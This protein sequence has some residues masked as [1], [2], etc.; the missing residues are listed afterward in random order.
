[1]HA[2][3]LALALAQAD[4]DP[5]DN[6]DAFEKLDSAGGVTM[7]RRAIKGSPFWE[8]RAEAKTPL[9]VPDLCVALFEWGTKG[10]EGPG[11][12][13]NKVLTDG[14]DERVV[15]TQISQPVVAN[16][17]YALTI[18]RERPT[19]DTC[20]IRFRTTNAVAP[21]SPDGFVRMEKLWG[22]WRVDPDEAGAKVTYTMFS[23]PAGAVP[24][25]LVHGPTKSATR[26]SIGLGIE[27]ARQ[28]VAG[29]YTPGKERKK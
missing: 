4:A 16:R 11:V 10:G 29:T 6:A 8:Y 15:Y 25:F 28:F 14:D 24:A 19:A 22:E 2:L 20:R 13:M 7:Y 9:K 17:D 18:R 12:M 26:E 27:R 5:F 1:M 21:K 23:D 3:L